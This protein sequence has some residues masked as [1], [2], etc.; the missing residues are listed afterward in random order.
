MPS[1]LR[2]VTRHDAELVGYSFHCPGCDT[3]HIYYTQPHDG[4]SFVDGKWIK[5][6]GPVWTFNGDM[7]NPTFTPSLLIHEAKWPDGEVAHPRCHLFV[8]NGKIDY[9]NDCG[10][11]YAG[12]QGVPMQDETP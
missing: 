5:K 11:A 4:G 12:K 2:R 7:E 10:H 9:C 6:P 3:F 1:K 8:R